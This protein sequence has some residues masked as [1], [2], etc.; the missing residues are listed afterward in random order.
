MNNLNIEKLISRQCTVQN[1]E[2]NVKFSFSEPMDCFLIEITLLSRLLFK[3]S[4]YIN[5]TSKA[6][7]VSI[8][9]KLYFPRPLTDLPQQIKQIDWRDDK[10]VSNSPSKKIFKCTSMCLLFFEVFFKLA[11]HSN[12]M[13]RKVF[14][15][16]TGSSAL[17]ANKSGIFS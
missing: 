7:K 3:E 9:P 14:L 15:L 17:V 1:K 12:G 10:F 16:C 8:Y 6:F 4:C 11:F 2:R 5:D 13:I